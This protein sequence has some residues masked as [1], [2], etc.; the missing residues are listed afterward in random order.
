[1]SSSSWAQVVHWELDAYMPITNVNRAERTFTGGFD[2]NTT[3]LEVF[4]VTIKSSGGCSSS[5]LCFDYADATGSV[6]TGYDDSAIGVQFQKRVDF[7]PPLFR[8]NRL[9][10]R[11]FDIFQPGT[12]DDLYLLETYYFFINE[13]LD[14][15][16]YSE[17]Y[18]TNCATLVGTL[19]PIPEPE[20]YAMLLAG[21]GLLGF[22][23]RQSKT[24]KSSFH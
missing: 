3:T 12:Y 22:R 18:C 24:R 5:G 20:T 13:P 8:Q 17:D 4:N 15:D 23:V 21:I 9:Y 7:E 11:D 14:P 10:I 16:I 1:M 2:F 19:A 6:W